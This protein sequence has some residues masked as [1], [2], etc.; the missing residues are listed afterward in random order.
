MTKNKLLRMNNVDIVVESI[1]QICHIK[2]WKR[3]FNNLFTK[4]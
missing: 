4:E 3:K 1:K 2:L